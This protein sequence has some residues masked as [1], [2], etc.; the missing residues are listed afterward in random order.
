MHPTARRNAGRKLNK[1]QVL[2]MEAR[3]NSSSGNINGGQQN[4]DEE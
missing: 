1:E 4:F 2:E 3:Y